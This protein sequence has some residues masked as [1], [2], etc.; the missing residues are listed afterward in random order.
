MEPFAPSFDRFVVDRFADKAMAVDRWGVL[1]SH[2]LLAPGRFRG[3]VQHLC[4]SDYRIVS[5]TCTLP[6]YASCSV[7]SEVVALVVVD[8]CRRPILANGRRIGIG[9]VMVL[10]EGS[11][12]NLCLSSGGSQLK[13]LLISRRRLQEAALSHLGRE[14]HLPVDQDWHS[15]MADPGLAH[16]L[17]DRVDSALEKAS[18]SA[19]T[20]IASAMAAEASTLLAAFIEALGNVDHLPARNRQ[21]LR[22]EARRGEILRKTEAYLASRCDLA[23]NGRDLSLHLGIGE[24]QI[25]RAFRDAYGYGPHHWHQLTRLHLA[26]TALQQGLGRAKVTEIAERFGFCH[27]GRFSVLYREFFGESPRDTGRAAIGA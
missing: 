2:R 10:S 13:A 16:N 19:V 25:E 24:R 1:T 12:L 3:C 14:L 6:L 5:W 17:R 8:G 21:C 11:S 9:E 7:D 27:L 15:C 18:Q 22:Y 4:F 26:R 23:Y 20:D